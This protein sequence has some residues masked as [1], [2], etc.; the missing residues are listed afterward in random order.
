MKRYLLLVACVA[1]VATAIV[2]VGF[3][4]KEKGS[5]VPIAI[6][7]AVKAMFPKANVKEVGKEKE[8][9]AVYEAAIIDE[10]KECDV[11]VTTD[12][13]VAGVESDEAADSLP[14]AVKSA[15]A[16]A[17]PGAKMGK[18]AK[19]IT[20]AELK[21]VKLSAPMTTYEVTVEKDGKEVELKLSADG[22]VISQKVEEADKEENGKDE[23]KGKDKEN[24]KHKEGKGG[25][26]DK[27]E[28]DNDEKD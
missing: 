19:E 6:T 9:I 20:Y 22:K 24:G 15:A 21:Y 28:K 23:E 17:L 27:G 16:A 18:A 25:E 26:K 13:M 4:E 3:A 14:D 7:A 2:S 8:S 1:I 5:T 12:G 11:T 10:N